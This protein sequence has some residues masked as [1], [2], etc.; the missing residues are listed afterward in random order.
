MAAMPATGRVVARGIHVIRVFRGCAVPPVARGRRWPVAK[1]AIPLRSIARTP[2]PGGGLPRPES[3]RQLLESGMTLILL[4]C[5]GLAHETA[6]FRGCAGT[7]KYEETRNGRL[8]PNATRIS[9]L[10]TRVKVLERLRL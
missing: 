8:K 9:W 3:W 5:N 10:R 6:G 1:A 4:A 7:K 2:Q